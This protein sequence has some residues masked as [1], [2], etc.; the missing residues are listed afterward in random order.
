MRYLEGSGSEVRQSL[1]GDDVPPRFETNCAERYKV[2]PV[3]T[4][5]HHF[6]GGAGYRGKSH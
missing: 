6:N 2:Y 1:C 5:V 3:I 4:S